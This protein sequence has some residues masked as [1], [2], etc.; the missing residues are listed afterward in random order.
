[1]E[2]L[3]F[4]LSAIVCFLISGLNPAIILSK[5]LYGKDI[6]ECG[7]K[8]PG[9]TNFKRCFGMKTAIVVFIVDL[10]KAALCVSILSLFFDR[11]LGNY[12]LGAAFC[13]LFC[14]LGHSYPIWYS[15]KGGKGFLVYMSVIFF[16]DWRCGLIAFA[17]L[18]VLLLTTKY[19]SLSAMLSVIS[20]V[21]SLAI[22]DVT[23]YWVLIL[24]SMQAAFIVW[25]HRSNIM[26][27]LSGTESKFSFKSKKSVG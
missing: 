2:Y 27:L 10:A 19:M 3:I 26:R 15:F 4:P 9:F 12:Q 6:R 25:R 7:S 16:V 5:L 22:L 17:L 20:T 11:L 24:C 21:I 8:N 1:M 18:T 13:G 14:M 23:S